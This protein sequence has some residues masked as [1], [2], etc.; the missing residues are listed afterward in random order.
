MPELPRGKSLQEQHFQS[1]LHLCTLCSTLAH[2]QRLV[3][4]VDEVVEDGVAVHSLV[5]QQRTLLR[6]GI[7]T[8]RGAVDDDVILFHDFGRDTFVLDG[9]R[10]LVAT[11]EDGFESQ[12]AQSVVDGFRRSSCSQDECLLVPFIFE[13]GFYA[14][15][16][17]DDIR[18]VALQLD[19]LTLVD[20]SDDVDGSDG[21]CLWRY[22]VEERYHLLLVGYGNV[23]AF[24]FWV[25][26]EHLGQ[27][28][29]GG[30]LEILVDSVDVFIMKPLVEVADGERV[31]QWITDESVLVHSGWV[32]GLKLF[33]CEIHRA[34][35]EGQ[36]SER[37]LGKACL[38]QDVHHA[39][40]LWKR[41]DGLGEIRVGAGV[42]GNKS[43]VDGQHRMRVDVE[44]LSHGE[45]DG[46]RQFHDAEV[47]TRL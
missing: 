27:D 20:D 26:T 42:F 13:H 32:V 44:Q 3:W 22:A 7:H 28:V 10:T 31:S 43:S 15:C 34:D 6:L 30:N 17:S 12:V 45:R 11:D 21:P 9:S 33:F 46:C 36:P 37:C 47:S 25:L 1:V 23:E 24:Q 2:K 41:F 18:V 39:L 35:A 5:R 40:A 8:Q 14:L 38:L 16:E 29:D 19:I 4:V